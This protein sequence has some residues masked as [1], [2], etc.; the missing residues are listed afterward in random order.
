[1]VGGGVSVDDRCRGAGTGMCEAGG[2][3]AAPP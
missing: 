1:M 3:G 2:E